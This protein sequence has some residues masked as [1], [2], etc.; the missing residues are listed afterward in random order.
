METKEIITLADNTVTAITKMSDGNPGAISAMVELLKHGER[1]DPQGIMGG[2]GFILDLDREGIYGTDIY[3]FWND[4]CEQ[5]VVKMIAVLR[6]VQLGFFSGRTLANACHRQDRS[7]KSMIPVD[8]LYEK[9]K[10]RLERFDR[11]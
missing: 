4:I 5:E 3:V 1:I 6:A 9:V 10:E 8:E 2:I 7:G 11:N